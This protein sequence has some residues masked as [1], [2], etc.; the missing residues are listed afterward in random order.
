MGRLHSVVLFLA[1]LLAAAAPAFAQGGAGSTGTILGQVSDESGGVLPGVTVS[2]TSPSLMGVRTVVT[3]ASGSYTLAG[4][5][6][7]EYAIVFDLPGFQKVTRQG[8]RITV[9]FTAEVP[10]KMGVQSLEETVTVSGESPVIDT[11]ATRVQTNFT[12]DQ[13]SSLPNSRDLWGLL[14][15][16]PSVVLNRVDVGGSTAGT[17]TTY[18]AY[19]YS[20]Q[21][22]PL[23]EGINTTEGTSAAGFYLDYG[24]FEE[25]FIGAAANSAEMPVPGVLS[26]FVSKSGGN[27]FSVNLYYDFETEGLQGTNLTPEQITPAPGVQA[28]RDEKA[29]RLTGYYNLNLGVG[30]PVVRDKL[31]FFGAYMRQQ[32]EVAQPPS[33][34]ILDGTIFKTLLFNYTGKV[35]YNLTP[36][37]KFIGYIQHGTK[38]QPNRTD[39]AA[40][41]SPRHLT[42]ASTLNQDSPSWVWKGEYQRTLGGTGFLEARYGQFGYDFGMVNNIQ[43]PRYED[44]VTFDV[45]GGGRDWLLKRRRNQ[46]TAAYSWFKNEFLGGNHNFKFGGEYQEETGNTIWNQGYTDSVV[47]L[48]RSGAASQVRLY[49]TPSSAWNGLANTSFFL[50]DS[51]AVKRFT[52][53][54]GLRFDRYRVFLPAQEHPG[55]RFF[56]TPATFAEVSNVVSF[57]H[58]APRLG[59]IYDLTGDGKTVLKANWGQFAYNP[60]VNLADSVNP[61]TAEQ[62]SLYNWTDRNADRLYQVGEETTLVQKFG[63]VANAAIDPDLENAYTREFSA[64]VERELVP[65]LGLKVG[66]V[67]KKD[68]NGYQ[69]VNALRPFDAFNVP[70]QIADPGAPGQFISAFNLDNTSRGTQNVTTNIDGYEGTYETME[71]SLNKRWTQNWSLVAS[72]SYIWTHEY[73][74]TYFGQRFGSTAQNFTFFGNFPNNP[75]DLTENDFTNWNMK[76]HGTLEPFWGLRFTPVLKV[77]SGAPYGRVVLGNL[78]YNSS[79][80]LLVEPIGTRRQETIT[81]FDLRTEKQFRFG[82]RARFGLFF[83]LF[84]LTNAN[85]EININWTTGT[86]FETPITVLPPRI[87]KFGV[88]FDF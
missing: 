30:G 56:P 70:V 9:G 76:I 42:A 73:A 27:R 28:F 75:N 38:Q 5:P 58:I 17:Q 37:N 22:R 26:Q 72:Y 63:G 44:L 25:V 39:A 24:S 62:Y 59:A 19:G 57:N 65:N 64:W 78:N 21:N 35:T 10:V 88:K 16:T 11:V 81:V 86:R 3:D 55:G 29:N 4:L 50:T 61:N 87:A 74:S 14:A 36:N 84:N 85:T 69:Q 43:E 60:G 71:V 80:Q 82:D 23:V 79:Q 53:N 46:F 49:A 47:H 34:Q 8:I 48:L 2:A 45:T 32:N 83:D 68:Y 12:R 20:G 77:Q 41:G 40:L 31:W 66:Y 67:W 1:V 13:L 51:W 6:A 33:G 54:L 52:M 18:F 7:G 15:A